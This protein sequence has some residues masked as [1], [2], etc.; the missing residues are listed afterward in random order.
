MMT[1]FPRG[2]TYYPRQEPSGIFS[3][4]LSN[5][6]LDLVPKVLI[7]AKHAS[8]IKPNMR[9]YSTVVGP[10]SSA[11]KRTIFRESDFMG[12]LYFVRREY[13]NPLKG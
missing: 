10:S 6:A 2:K 5:V 7:A 1:A 13:G 4:K 8:T 9:A 12:F 11:R 3:A